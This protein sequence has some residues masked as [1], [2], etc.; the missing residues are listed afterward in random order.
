MYFTFSRAVKYK[1][2][3]YSITVEL[4]KYKKAMGSSDS[5]PANKSEGCEFY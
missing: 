5:R 2:A 4:R 1:K 3:V